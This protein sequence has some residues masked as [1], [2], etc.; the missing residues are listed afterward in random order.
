M[1]TFQ[2]LTVIYES[3]EIQITPMTL[4]DYGFL[5]Q[6]IFSNPEQTNRVTRKMA[7]C[8]NNIFSLPSTTI[9]QVIIQSK[10]PEWTSIGTIIP[11]Q[12]IMHVTASKTSDKIYPQ[13]NLISC[14]FPTWICSNPITRQIQ[15]YIAYQIASHIGDD[16][17]YTLQPYQFKLFSEDPIQKI[18]TINYYGEVPFLFHTSNIKS[19]KFFEDYI[20]QQSENDYPTNP[21]SNDDTDFWDNLSEDSMANLNNQMDP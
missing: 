6:L 5:K 10:M 12:H 21:P 1:S 19:V 20:Q 18:R 7:I 3:Q 14:E 2:D 13:F 16:D 17:V 8:I 9:C 15:D 11:T 4:L